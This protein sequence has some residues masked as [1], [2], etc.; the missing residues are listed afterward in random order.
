[1]TIQRLQERIKDAAQRGATLDIRGHGSK[2]FYGQPPGA[3]ETLDISDFAGV[4]SYEPS[5]LVVTVKAGTAISELEALLA[6]QGQHL[7]FEPPRFGGRGTVGGMVAAG[8]SGPARAAAG[9]VRDHILGLT[10]INGRAEALSF[11]GTV[12]KNVAGY[13]VSRLMAGSLG[14]LGL[15]AEV[16]IKVLPRPV[17]SAT[18]RFEMDQAQA[19][20]ELNRWGGQPLPIQ[21]SAWWDG[22]LVLRLAGAQ[23]AVGTAIKTLGG[24]TI[25][26]DLALP[27]WEGL[28]D[29]S[30]VF[31]QG[32]ERAVQGGARLWRLSVP[33]TAPALHLHGEQLIEWGGAQRWVTTALPP[34]QV[35]EA[36]AAAGGH[37]TLFRAL[38]KSPGVFAPLSPPLLRI[39]R[40]LKQSFDP[41]GLFNPGRLYPDL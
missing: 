23:A 15:I 10:L 24:E 25:A 32:A 8:L 19:L 40:A 9:S 18:L 26:Q 39:H 2:A 17:A 16:S 3:S 33:Q 31:F 1:M 5:E 12:M 36:T 20:R 27:F 21:A 22:A 29:Q 6:A 34:A 37:A 13:D 7:A 41:Q 28:R 35:R 4:S 30:D 11:G 14:V 38:D